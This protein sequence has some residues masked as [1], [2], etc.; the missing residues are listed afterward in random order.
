MILMNMQ[1]ARSGKIR[2]MTTSCTDRFTDRSCSLGAGESSIDP[3][4]AFV[5]PETIAAWINRAC[6]PVVVTETCG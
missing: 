2:H 4:I 5:F 1:R 3:S 6:Q